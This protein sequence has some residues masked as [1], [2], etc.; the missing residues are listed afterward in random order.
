MQFVRLKL[1]HRTHYIPKLFFNQ[2]QFNK[3]TTNFTFDPKSL[4]KLTRRE[5]QKL[6][7]EASIPANQKS[8]VIRAKLIEKF[9]LNDPKLAR[10]YFDDSLS[11]E[12]KYILNKAVAGEN[13]F[14]TGGAGTG[15]SHLVSIF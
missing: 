12:Q 9:E 14:F 2:I 1:F 4:E 8:E 11:N 5:L 15:K 6:A 7:K 3:Y 13:L 10:K